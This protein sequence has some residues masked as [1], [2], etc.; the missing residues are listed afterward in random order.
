M[1]FAQGVFDYLSDDDACI[2]EREPLE[3][4]AHEGQLMTYRHKGDFFPM[5]TYRDH[6]A[7]NELWDAGKA[8]WKIW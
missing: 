8:P 4:L 3:R 1:V 7:L 2:L 5:D 6:V